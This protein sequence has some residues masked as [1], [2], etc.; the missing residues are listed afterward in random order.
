MLKRSSLF[1]DMAS[2]ISRVPLSFLER[3][4][5]DC[6]FASQPRQKPTPCVI[7]MGTRDENK[8]PDHI[9]VST[10]EPI[11]GAVRGHYLAFYQGEECLGGAQILSNGPSSGRQQTSSNEQ[12]PLV[13]YSH[14]QGVER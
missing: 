3:G 4:S 10:A 5:L 7:T 14:L 11:T 12:K 13:D 9:V 2:W 1:V 6:R 8:S